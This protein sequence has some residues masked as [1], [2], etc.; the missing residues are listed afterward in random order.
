MGRAH[1]TLSRGEE[2][3][4]TLKNNPRIRIDAI[5]RRIMYNV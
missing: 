5:R 2:A 3:L 4:S 1:V